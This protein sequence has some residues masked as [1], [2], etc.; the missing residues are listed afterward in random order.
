MHS[1]WHGFFRTNFINTIVPKNCAPKT[2]QSFQT[3]CH[4]TCIAS[5][6]GSETKRAEL[7]ARIFQDKFHQRD[8]PEKLVPK[9]SQTVPKRWAKGHAWEKVLCWSGF[10]FARRSVRRCLVFAPFAAKQTK[11][12]P[13]HRICISVNGQLG[14]N[15]LGKALLE[16]SDTENA[17]LLA[18]VLHSAT[19]TQR[20]FTQRSF[21]RRIFYTEKL[22]HREDFTHR[23]FY[24][25]KLLHRKGFS[26][27]DTEKLAHT[28]AFT[29]KPLHR[30]AF[31]Q[32]SFYTE[33]LVHAEALT[34][35]SLLHREVFT[36]RSFYTERLVHTEQLLHTET[37]THTE[38][39]YTQKLSHTEAFTQESFYTGKPLHREALTHRSFL[40]KKR[41]HRNF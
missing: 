2:C 10:H 34:Q 17:E 30:A 13:K 39:L 12:E 3:L 22:V 15:S 37:F 41:L 25:E 33:K 40:H 5:L 32:S 8:C 20:S 4:G 28:E 6:A 19:F 26:S 7:L 11:R 9:T 35:R 29:Q 18:R 1:C 23:V 38:E 14:G 31:T 16:G 27:L 24:A 36:Q 21:T